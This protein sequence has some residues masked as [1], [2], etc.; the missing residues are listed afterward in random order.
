MFTRGVVGIWVVG[1]ILPPAFFILVDILMTQN[2]L[3]R[4]STQ[5]SKTGNS[6]RKI[7]LRRFVR[8]EV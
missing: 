2:S 1:C 8:N 6:K 5:K 4:N 7:R 3:T